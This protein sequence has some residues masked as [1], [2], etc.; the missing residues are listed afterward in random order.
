MRPASFPGSAR[1][2]ATHA[3]SL[4][5]C[6]AWVDMN[7]AMSFT[8]WDRSSATSAHAARNDAHS[9]DSASA[10]CRSSIM[11]SR[12]PVTPALF[13][14][15]PIMS[16]HSGNSPARTADPAGRPAATHERTTTIIAS[17]ISVR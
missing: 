11:F 6:G 16:A 15:P 8:A 7:R 1:P 17:T 4:S 12:N 2:A 13:R 14:I 10:D 3:W 5:D 9:S